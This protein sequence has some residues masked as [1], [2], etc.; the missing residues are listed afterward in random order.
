VRDAGGRNFERRADLEREAG[1]ARM[2]APVRRQEHVRKLGQGADGGLQECTLAEG[3][4]ARLV[5]RACRACHRCPVTADDAAAHAGSPPRRGHSPRTRSTRRRRRSE[6]GVE[7]PR[8]RLQ[9]G[10]PHL[11]IDESLRGERP[12]EHG[13]ILAMDALVTASRASGVVD[14]ASW[15]RSRS[16][17]ARSSCPAEHG[18]FANVNRPITIPARSSHNPAVPCRAHGRGARVGRCRAR[19]RSR[20]RLGPG[21]RPC[22]P[23]SHARCSARPDQTRPLC[24]PVPERGGLAERLDAI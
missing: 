7:S 3:E 1:S 15:P 4:Q 6:P 5:P 12:G 17:R 10:Q 22:L 8:R 2:V 16:C 9:R 14:S 23:N 24:A 19:A 20:H 13:C 21:R 11:L 18:E